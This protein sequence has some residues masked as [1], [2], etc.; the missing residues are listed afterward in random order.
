MTDHSPKSGNLTSAF[1]RSSQTQSGESLEYVRH[2]F[3]MILRGIESDELSMGGLTINPSG[4]QHTALHS[5]KRNDRIVYD[6][7]MMS[8]LDRAEAQL[9]TLERQLA[10]RH[11]LL[12]Q[13][14]G[15]D[16][17][18]GM[19]S[20]YLNEGQLTGL[21][22]EEEKLEA[23]AEHVLDANGNI[24]SKFAHLEEA[25]YVRDWKNAQE[26]RPVVEK[27]RGRDYLTQDEV[28]EVQA[29]SSKA[30]LSENSSSIMGSDN[31]AYKATVNEALDE[32]L[33]EQE[34][35]K[36]NSHLTFG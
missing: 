7:V 9:A 11:E 19:A 31:S 25:K 6:M 30:S 29:A 12:R 35:Q 24:K 3:T 1:A 2:N 14:Y 27:Y 5:S 16:V 26:L 4:R 23:L 32:D 15:N 10:Q 8:I 36:L 20:T 34:S 28:R 13:K 22:T 17:I 18:G 33:A 21:T